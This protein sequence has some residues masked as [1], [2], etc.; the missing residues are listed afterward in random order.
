MDNP[1]LILASASPRRADILNMLGLPFA[2][3]PTDVEEVR[4]RLETPE[5]YVERLA[6]SKAA[7]GAKANEGKW[8]LAGDTVV[9]LDGQILEKPRSRDDAFE[10]LMGLAGKWHTVFSGLALA[11]PKL[12]TH[13]RVD[14][15]EVKF[16][17]FPAEV[18]QRYLDTEEPFDKAG[19]YGIQGFG[20]ALVE[21]VDG[22]FYTVVGM[23]VSGLVM[24]L[25][26][27]GR[28][29]AFPIR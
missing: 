14:R 12:R 21:R 27:A 7:A 3:A 15:A 11:D 13:S 5:E 8:V 9:S 18:A 24:L 4:Q 16:R 6:R 17:T 23:S 22:D 29:Y 10:M 28:P 2:V 25:E 20:A 19:S 1:P 26:L